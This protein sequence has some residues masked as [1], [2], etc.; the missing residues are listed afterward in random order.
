MLRVSEMVRQ[1]VGKAS[2]P[3]PF[4]G[5]PRLRR[6][7]R[8]ATREA[9]AQKP[10]LRSYRVTDPVGE[11]MWRRAGGSGRGT[12]VHMATAQLPRRHGDIVDRF[13][14]VVATA[15]GGQI[16]ALRRLYSR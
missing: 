12:F 3:G 1:T 10:V 7:L 13:V 15:R 5:G 16:V 6:I 9:G 4:R 2:L 14:S 8:L 11:R